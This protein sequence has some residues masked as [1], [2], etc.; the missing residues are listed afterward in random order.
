MSS[1]EDWKRPRKVASD[2]KPTSAKRNATSTPHVPRARP[3]A[4]VSR[5]VIVKVTGRTNSPAALRAQLSYITRKGTLPGELPNG[6][7]LT[8]LVAL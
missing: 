1:D 4:T 3:P 7:T 2:G 8:G 6:Q 5:E